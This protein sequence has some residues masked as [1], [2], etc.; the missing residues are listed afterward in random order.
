MWRH[1]VARFIELCR[2]IN[3]WNRNVVVKLCYCDMRLSPDNVCDVKM[4]ANKE[5]EEE[6]KVKIGEDE[7]VEQGE[8][9]EGGKG[10]WIWS[11]GKECGVRREGE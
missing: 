10:K 9:E 3:K 5:M 1:S 6:E 11:Y 4:E 7:A 2:I 8:K